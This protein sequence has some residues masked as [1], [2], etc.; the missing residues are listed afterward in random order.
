[1]NKKKIHEQPEQIVFCTECGS[2]LTDFY[3]TGEAKD[4]KKVK[5]HYE[6]CRKT[7]KFKGDMCSRMFIAL[8][9]DFPIEDND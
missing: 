1:M 6:N 4:E 5:E 8:D 3:K 7:G 9:F 2:A